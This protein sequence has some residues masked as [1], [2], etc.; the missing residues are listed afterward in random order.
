MAG[1]AASR[2]TLHAWRAA[3]PHAFAAA[4]NSSRSSRSAGEGEGEDNGDDALESNGMHIGIQHGGGGVAAAAAQ[5]AAEAAAL[6]WSPSEVR[7][8]L[9]AANGQCIARPPLF[10]GYM[11]T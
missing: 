5:A 4:R 11:S 8:R 10:F 6:G 9:C 2:A 7:G 3:Q 1:D